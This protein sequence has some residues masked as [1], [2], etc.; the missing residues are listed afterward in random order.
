MYY[1]R[2]H[3][4]QDKFTP[5]QPI[6]G[7]WLVDGGGAVAVDRSNHV[8]VFWHSAPRESQAEDR[9]VYMS[10]SSDSGKTF[11]AGRP[12]GDAGRG[13]CPCCSM[14]A[15]VDERGTVYVVYRAAD[16][17]VERDID[18]LVSKDVGAT[19]ERLTLD[20]WRLEACPMS[21]MAFCE[22]ER[23]VLVA[24]ETEG[25]IRFTSIEKGTAQAGPIHAPP[26]GTQGG[27]HP[28]FAATPQGGYLLA[29]TEGTGWKK[30]GSVAWQA[31][32]A[33]LSPVGEV[34]RLAATV[35][36]WSFAAAY[37]DQEQSVF[38]VLH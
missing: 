19:F 1:A 36:V 28:V 30:G 18:L 8:F 34:Q 31:Y 32:D 33:T 4:A 9:Q 3:K 13:V 24:W 25:Q 10:V 21:S 7:P 2:L 11:D 15:T 23:S 5:Q 12:I 14:Q 20:R 6:S 26:G 38:Q 37:Y 17:N 22:T 27:K 35:P 16:K 29:W